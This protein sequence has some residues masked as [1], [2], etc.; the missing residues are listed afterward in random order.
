[1]SDDSAL[2]VL[3]PEV[4]Q[5]NTSAWSGDHCMDPDVVPGVLL[6]NQR[7][8]TPAPALQSLA[9]AILAEIGIPGFPKGG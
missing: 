6:T 2:G 9:G 5:D 7:M 4:F 1:V 8:R 3:S